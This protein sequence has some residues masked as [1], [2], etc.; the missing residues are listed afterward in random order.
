MTEAR[1]ARTLAFYDSE[2]AVYANAGEQRPSRA[3][4][5]FLAKLPDRADILDLGCGGGRDSRAMIAAG[6]RVEATDGCAAMAA[7]A[8]KRI[9]QPVRVMRFD[10]LDADEAYDG[11]WA[12]ASLLHVPRQALAETI[13]KIWRALRPGG[14]HF[15]NFKAGEAEGR[16]KA[17]RYFNYLSAD[18]TV[19]LYQRAG[20][21]Q[22]LEMSEGMG[23]GYY[24]DPTRWI[25]IL[26]QKPG[27][28][29]QP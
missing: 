25:G 15:A 27:E 3:L 10:E 4:A 22:A 20:P 26:A 11:I 13:A 18:L 12:H 29:E 14:W 1:D 9:G 7:Q 16:D 2:A 23:R 24:N 8:E 28:T 21:W 5:G 19:A 17:G 6:H